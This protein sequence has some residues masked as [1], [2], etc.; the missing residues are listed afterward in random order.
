LQPASQGIEIIGFS[1]DGDTRL[2]K[3]M[4]LQSLSMYAREINLN[5]D[6]LNNTIETAETAND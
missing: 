4:Q 2:L 1:S 6:V 3:A 5:V